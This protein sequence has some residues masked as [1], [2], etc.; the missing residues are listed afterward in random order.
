MIIQW[1]RGGGF[2][3]LLLL[4]LTWTQFSGISSSPILALSVMAI[5]VGGTLRRRMHLRNP[6][7]E[8]IISHEKHYTNLMRAA[9][10]YDEWANAASMLDMD[11]ALNE[12]KLYD[13]GFVLG[14]LEELQA[15]RTQ[16]SIDD[17]LFSLRV[18]V[19]RNLGNICNP[20][21]HKGRQQ[22]PLVVQDYIEEFRYKHFRPV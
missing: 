13:E 18:D 14:K 8:E 7:S 22:L 2:L 10:T 20:R 21:L 6:G 11:G 16:G 19:T 3:V 5:V 17:V 1:R 12:W 4:L 9:I 15:R